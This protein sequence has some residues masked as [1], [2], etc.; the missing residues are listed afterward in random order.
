LGIEAV[1]AGGAE[2]IIGAGVDLVGRFGG[3]HRT[4][5][6]DVIEDMTGLQG[7]EVGGGEVADVGAA[8]DDMPFDVMAVGGGIAAEVSEIDGALDVYLADGAVCHLGKGGSGQ[9]E[10]GEE[11]KDADTANGAAVDAYTM[12]QMHGMNFFKRRGRLVPS[13]PDFM[14][15][16]RTKRR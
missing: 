5:E 3:F 1:A 8:I 12:M 9:Q 4:A 6:V 16:K 7:I 11:A 2:D 13:P 10:E 15:I 14:I